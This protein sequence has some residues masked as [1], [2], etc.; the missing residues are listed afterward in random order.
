M[1][2]IYV[3]QLCLLRFVE[4]NNYSSLKDI[5]LIIKF[6]SEIRFIKNNF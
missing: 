4:R 1:R 6:D 5:Q 2:N 3:L